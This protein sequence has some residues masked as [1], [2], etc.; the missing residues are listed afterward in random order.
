M[1]KLFFTILSFLSLGASLTYA[2][3]FVP[4][5]KTQSFAQK[6][7]YFHVPSAFVMYA[8]LFLGAV[9]SGL[10]LY[11]RKQTYDQLAKAAMY[12]AT[13]FACLVMISGPIW[14][15]PIWGIYWDWDPRLTTTFIVFVLLIAY[16]IARASLKKSPRPDRGPTIGAI[17]A[18]LALVDV[19]I[20]H[21]SVKIW[22]GLHPSVLRNA[23]ALPDSFQTALEFMIL[24]C[25]LVGACLFWQIYRSLRLVEA[26]EDL[27]LRSLRKEGNE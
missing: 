3:L 21:L 27:R 20:I 1:L 9:F 14:A 26:F 15:K 23:D 24:S 12:T 7:F 18:I 5:E 6:I 4:L 22:R 8:F 11:D 10:Y 13:L 19:P 2:L 25:F 16:V 17:L